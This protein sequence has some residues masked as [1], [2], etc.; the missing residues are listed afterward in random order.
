MDRVYTLFDFCPFEFVE[1]A[2]CGPECGLFWVNVLCE[3]SVTVFF[4]YKIPT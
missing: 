2:F 3:L 4:S 1:V